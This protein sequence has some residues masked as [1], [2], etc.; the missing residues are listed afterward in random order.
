[1]RPPPREVFSQTVWSPIPYV[2]Q[3]RVPTFW[4]LDLSWFLFL[5]RQTSS[6][7]PHHHD[8][9]DETPFSARPPLVVVLVELGGLA[10]SSLRPQHLWARYTPQVP[11]HLWREYPSRLQCIYIIYTSVPKTPCSASPIVPTTPEA[12]AMIFPSKSCPFKARHA[13]AASRPV[14]R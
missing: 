5:V 8:T 7:S 13:L 11:L 10:I 9:V 4:S 6:R 2:P 14:W 12:V 1:M 3:T